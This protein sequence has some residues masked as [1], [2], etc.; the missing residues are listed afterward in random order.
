MANLKEV[1]SQT[2]QDLQ[3]EHK[4]ALHVEKNKI[5]SAERK[6]SILHM[7]HDNSIQIKALLSKHNLQ[8]RELL[9]I[10]KENKE[11]RK[12]AWNIIAGS[13]SA[14]PSSGKT[15]DN[16]FSK[17]PSVNGSEQ[18]P[19]SKKLNAAHVSAAA[20]LLD[21]DEDGMARA[22]QNREIEI[23]QTQD[24]YLRAK[25]KLD[26][27]KKKQQQEFTETLER[28]KLEETVLEDKFQD[29]STQMLLEQEEEK[30]AFEEDCNAEIHE[31]LEVQEREL[32]MEEHIRGAETKAL[33]ERKVLSSLLDTFVD[34]VISIDPMGF[35]KRFKYFLLI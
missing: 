29:E 18:K 22:E 23:K 2:E 33:I 6:I 12:A 13:Q 27:L 16:E 11:K 32:A 24:S 30:Q 1:H 4:K 19:A 34:G 9:R 21:E 15:P 10:Q 5:N 17:D 7:Q 31:A 25:T 28:H 35:I 20:E 3:N 14:T 26:E 8:K